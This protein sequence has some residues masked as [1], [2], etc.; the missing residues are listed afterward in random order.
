MK[1]SLILLS[2][3]ASLA[4]FNAYAKT[5][6][7]YIGFDILR[8]NA[9]VKTTKDKVISNSDNYFNTNRKDSSIGLGLNYSH[10]FNFD[11]F[12][13]APGAFFDLLNNETKV[14]DS[15]NGYN[16]DVN[17]KSRYGIK[18]NIGYDINDQFSAYI[19]LG[20]SVNRYELITKDYIGAS[21]L[22]VTQTGSESALIYGLGFAYHPTKEL[23]INLEYNN[24]SFDIKSKTN[25]ALI[26]FVKLKSNVNL[27]VIKLGVSYNF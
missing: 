24:S 23:A 20:I 14:R 13:V 12:F 15:L 4:S 26:N 18:A 10:A 16:Q 22:K 6:G 11:K 9:E 17:I 8:S 21:Y 25:V 3:I 27:N 2:I 19:P 5:E 7:R 1:K